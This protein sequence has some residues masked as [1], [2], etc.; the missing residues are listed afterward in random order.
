MMSVL[1]TWA[2]ELKHGVSFVEDNINYIV[3]LM[4]P[5]R[6]LPEKLRSSYVLYVWFGRI[7]K[8]NSDVLF[9][10]KSLNESREDGE[11][12]RISHSDREVLHATRIGVVLLLVEGSNFYVN[13]P[14]K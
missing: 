14:T 10:V 13:N 12:L 2:F 6:Y 3:D 7:M 9:L 11:E 1:D 8:K 4:M 5:S